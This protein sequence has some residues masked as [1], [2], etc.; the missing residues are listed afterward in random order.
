MNL[1]IREQ[2]VTKR[3]QGVFALDAMEQ[4]VKRFPRKYR[5]AFRDKINTI[6]EVV[7]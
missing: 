5:F 6:L 2:G 3:C 1:Y 4:L 7:A